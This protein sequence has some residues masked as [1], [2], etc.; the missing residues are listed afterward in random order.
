MNVLERWEKEII[1]N[2]SS[3]YFNFVLFNMCTFSR[4]LSKFEN[5]FY[6]VIVFH[7]IFIPQTTNPLFYK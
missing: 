7:I 3:I 1:S 6:S 2:K 4:S 5:I